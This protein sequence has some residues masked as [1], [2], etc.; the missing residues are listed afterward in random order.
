ML[1]ADTVT[2]PPPIRQCQHRKDDGEQCR[3]NALPGKPYCNMA[4][5]RR[6]ALL[7]TRIANFGRRWWGVVTFCFGLIVAV[8]TIYGYITRIYVEPYSTVRSREPMGTVFN[9]KNNGVF[10]LHNVTHGCNLLSVKGSNGNEIGNTIVE[11]YAFSLGDLR[12]GATKSLSCEHIVKGF[13]GE[14]SI[15]IIIDYTSALQR[16]KHTKTFRFHSEQADDGT[17]VWKSD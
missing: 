13:T 16:S 1:P 17:W 14:A 6:A 3:K 2:N 10:D 4:S 11:P 7:R 8:P 12:A 9:L 15:E 5:H